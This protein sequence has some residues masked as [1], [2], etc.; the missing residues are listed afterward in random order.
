M[1]RERLK[2]SP[3]KSPRSFF[4]RPK[5]KTK[6]S[7]PSRWNIPAMIWGGI[8][9]T[10]MV[11]GGVIVVSAILG[12]VLST[13][14]FGDKKTALPKDMI[15]MF[16]LSDGL[17]ENAA[18]PSL[19]DPFA[20]QSLTVRDMVAAIDHAATDEHVHG[21]I[22]NVDGGGME[23]AHI[24]EVRSAIKRFRSAGKMTKAYSP[25]YGEAG[26]TGLGTYYLASAFEEIWMQPVGFVSLAGINLEMPFLKDFFDKLGIR[27]EFLKREEYKNAMETFT[28][29]KMSP[30]SREMMQNIVDDLA[31]HMTK[32]IAVSRKMS[33]PQ[34][35]AFMDH[36]M[37]T[38]AQ[39][40]NVK[41][42]DRLDDG[43]TLVAEWKKKI[44]GN[45][46]D[47]KI[48]LVDMSEYASHMPVVQGKDVAVVYVS[49]MIVPSDDNGASAAADRIA[50]ALSDVA[51]DKRF[52]AVVLRVDS[53]GGSPTA[54]E[55]IRRAVVRAK[56]KGKR[57]VVSMGAV[58]ASGGYWVSADADKIFA[59]P[60]TLT[61][62][63]GVVMGKPDLSG[64][65]TK[66]GVGWDGASL[67]T[68][69]GL[70][71]PNK[72]FSSEES[73]L[74][75]AHL[76]ST[77]DAFLTRVAAG[78]KMD[79][80]SVRQVA[81]GRAWT[82]AQAVKI[83][84]VDELGGL[85]VAMD[86]VAKGMGLTDRHDL[87]PVILPAPETPIEQ[88]MAALHGQVMVGKILKT[89]SPVIDQ[90]LSITASWG[91]IHNTNVY[92]PTLRL[93]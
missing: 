9:K 2:Y 68:N 62:S 17:V 47:E 67:G 4:Y 64:L 45:P 8:K 60:S 41:L 49:G 71:S 88:F 59:N 57:V 43:H 63:I 11:I 19:L 5:P 77:Y 51:D 30:A 83:G 42:I 87:N 61:G 86:D 90:F 75:N 53:P 48:S 25:S 36:G 38:D 92:D 70:W 21:L 33:V 22:L 65:W 39:A 52:S 14:I 7:M 46:D 89:L 54:S 23:P 29:S 20:F 18:S 80:E 74:I 34:V 31:S 40:L 76:D 85:D 10:C 69:S 55:T 50:E 56:Q 37:F 58:A 93:R 78:R 24:E 6:E 27:A 16:N 72:A 12:M 1:L 15:L 73:K 26:G 79:K 13:L 66:L 28:D 32:A 44:S 84:L 35:H 82:G 3:M 91:A 81:K